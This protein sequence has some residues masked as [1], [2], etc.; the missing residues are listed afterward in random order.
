MSLLRIVEGERDEA[1]AENARLQAR[2]E[3]AEAL[4]ERRKKALELALKRDP[5]LHP[6]GCDCELCPVF[7]AAIEEEGKR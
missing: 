4:A 6:E 1:R 5:G 2:V 3:E 7:R